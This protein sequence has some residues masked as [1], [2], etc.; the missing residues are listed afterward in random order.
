MRTIIVDFSF[1]INILRYVLICV[2]DTFQ[3][4]KSKRDKKKE[5]RELPKSRSQTVNTNSGRGSKGSSDRRGHNTSSQ[6]SLTEYGASKSKP[7]HKKQNGITVAPVSSAVES[8]AI[9]NLTK[10][11]T[12]ESSFAPIEDTMQKTNIAD[13]IS[14]PLQF[15]SSFQNSWLGKPGHVSMADIVKRG[16][17]EGKHPTVP[18]VASVNSYRA[19][20]AAITNVSNHNAKQSFATALT[21]ESEEKVDSFQESNHFSDK[22]HGI[23]TAEHHHISNDGWSLVEEQPAESVLTTTEITGDSLAYTNPSELAAPNLMVVGS[24]L[25]IDPCSEDI[26]DHDGRASV[27]PQ[28]IESRSISALERELDVEMSEDASHFD[29]RLLSMDPYQSEDLEFDC[30]KAEDGLEISS[31]AATLRQLSVHEEGKIKTKAGPA[32]IIPDY[33]RVTNVDCSQLSFGSFGAGAFSRSFSL[34]PPESNLK[35][36]PSVDDDY[37]IDES[38]SRDHEYHSNEQLKPTLT[39]NVA[40]ITC[41]PSENVDVSSISQPEGSLDATNEYGF[42]SVSSY[43]LPSSTQPNATHTYLHGNSQIKN[44]SPF[45]SLMQANSLQNNTLAASF[46]HLPDIDRPLSPLLTNQHASTRYGTTVSSIGGPSSSLPEVLK[47]TMFPNPQSTP[48]S[49][50]TTTLLTSPAFPQALPVPH[51]S[52]PALPLGHFANLL[53]YPIL[54]Q[55]YPYLPP[56]QQ[57]LSAVSPYHQSTALPNAGMKY[58]QLQYI[59]NLP[60]SSLPQASAISHYGGFGSSS[61]IPGGLNLTHT[62]ASNTT[63]GINEAL[64]QQYREASH[65]LSLQQQNE[66]PSMW[67]YGAGSR[68]TPPLPPS[69]LFNYQGQNQQSSFRQVQQPSQLGGFGYSNMYLSQGG[70]SREHLQNPNEVNLNGSQTTT[71]SQPPSQIWQQGY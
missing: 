68:T 52:Q 25:Q 62:T 14:T 36:V 7:M 63:I 60:T 24:D 4:V 40:S 53:S 35:V 58:S 57:T 46:P 49:L 16:R 34:K 23:G 56:M 67:I 26:Q 3:E 42:P 29:E 21:S 12:V 47:P 55:S 15:S 1:C 39:E 8:A 20:N 69:T 28:P 51:Y 13:G 61:S 44:L 33:L 43:G 65:F 71:Q 18:V 64:S 38:D 2:A 54:P 22:S 59:S 41:T 70:S 11:P 9:V 6:S 32:L 19:H 66:D 30:H 31:T 5:V 27:K 50:P 10:R 48:V 17:P 45:P 37:R